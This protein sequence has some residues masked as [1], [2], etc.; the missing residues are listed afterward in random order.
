M[1]SLYGQSEK[2][3]D[4]KASRIA[5]L[6]VAVALLGLWL[7][8]IFRVWHPLRTG[9]PGGKGNS[10]LTLGV[11]TWIG[12]GSLY[13]AQE[14]G[15][16]AGTPV[17]L[18]RI[19][20]TA[21]YNSAML[22]GDIDGFCNTMD[23]FV[24]AASGGVKGHVVYLFDESAGADGLIAKPFIRSLEDLRGRRIAAQTGWPGHFFMLYLTKQ[25]GLSPKDYRHINLDSDKA[26]SAF[27]SGKLDAAVTWEP[28]LSKI[29]SAGAGHILASSKDHPGI[30]MDGLIMRP[31][32]VARNDGAVRILVN[33]CL[34]A[35]EFWQ[36]HPSEGNEIVARHF[37]LS[38]DEVGRMVKGVKYL[39]RA[40]NLEYL[41]PNGRAIQTL[42]LASEVWVEAGVIDRAPDMSDAVT[43]KYVQ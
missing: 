4:M 18:R 17:N 26:G 1:R 35:V 19:D 2:E 42:R 16:F 40:T 6:I 25:A 29:V 11:A 36:S 15:F 38:A 33:G 43:D 21:V 13:I 24:L 8:G 41:E 10:A 23:S 14:K 7:V 27:M 5:A 3:P 31:A 34:K 28:W 37:G 9:S 12:Y 32:V 22:K 39:D 20:D 30:I